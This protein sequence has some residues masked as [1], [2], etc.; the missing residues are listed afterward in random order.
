MKSFDDLFEKSYE[1]HGIAERCGTFGKLLYQDL[2]S[3]GLIKTHKFSDFKYWLNRNFESRY[4]TMTPTDEDYPRSVLYVTLESN[5]KEQMPLL[6]KD[7]EKFINTFGYFIGKTIPDDFD[8]RLWKI[9][10]EPKFPVKLDRVRAYPNF[11]HITH[12]KYLPKIKKIGLTPRD[13][14][15]MFTHPGGRI[16]L[17][18]TT[19]KHN[20]IIPDMMSA[21]A[22]SKN[23]TAQKQNPTKYIKMASRN[24]EWDSDELVL[25]KIA[26]PE[27]YT[28][29][30]DPMLPINEYEGNAGT[31]VTQNITPNLIQIL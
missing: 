27:D 29:Y 12:K 25:L 1:I 4:G 24:L 9:I 31:F 18:N 30:Y 23:L 5:T 10:I 20:K 6:F 13:T 15:T 19:S 2:L 22:M 28:V 26:L 16:Y 14:Q 11:Y 3:E 7:L 21:L 8:L 17:I